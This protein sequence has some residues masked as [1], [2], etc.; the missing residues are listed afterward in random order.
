MK[1]FDGPKRPEAIEIVVS[2]NHSLSSMSV[3][4]RQAILAVLKTKYRNVRI[5]VVNNQLDLDEVITR[6]PDL[7]FLGMKFVPTDIALGITD[8][9]KVWLTERLDNADI[10]YTGSSREAN[11]LEFNKQHAK[12]RIAQ[13]GLSTAQYLVVPRGSNLIEKEITLRY[14]LFVKPLD[15]GGG[16][17]IDDGSLVH[18]FDQLKARVAVLDNDLRADTLIE[19]YLPGREFSIGILKNVFTGQYAALPIEI[20]APQNQAGDRFLSSAVKSADAETT[21]PVDDP[22]LAERIKTLGLQAFHALGATDYGRID[23]RLDAH[24]E[25]HFLEANL[26]PSLIDNYGNFPKTCLLNLGLSHQDLIFQLVELGLKVDNDIDNVI[27]ND[28]SLLPDQLVTI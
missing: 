5:S 28:L 22:L 25:P 8:P 27:K 18:H 24:G 12:Q 9:N 16:A 1:L 4:S 15:R 2:S 19:E 11:E 14:P 10:S 13:H 7:V 23:I 21:C 3:F 26:L 20:V 6:K 17:G